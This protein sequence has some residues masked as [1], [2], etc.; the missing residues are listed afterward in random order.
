MSVTFPLDHSG[1]NPA[2]LVSGELHSV[3]EAQ[4][5]DYFFL[6]PQFAPFY[7]DNFQLELI[8]GSTVQ[9]LAEDVH[10]SF[11]IPYVT[12]Q[13]VT[14]KAMYGAVTLHD[15]ENTGILRMRYQTLGGDQV[16]DRLQ[17]LTH[18]AD[19]AYNP[20]T[21]IWD[22]ITNVPNALPPTPHYQDY[23][24]FK[25]QEDVV[26]SLQAIVG[27]IG[28]NSSLTAQNIQS[29][30]ES[31]NSG[32]S[33]AYL[34]RSGGLMEG[35][36]GLS[37]QPTLPEHAVTKQY[38]DEQTINAGALTQIL[39]QYAS[40]PVLQTN[41]NEKVSKTGDVMTGPL[42]LHADPVV[43]QDAARK[44]YVDTLVT[45]LQNTLVQLQ[46]AVTDL[47]ASAANK[48]Q[49]DAQINELSSR[50]MLLGLQRS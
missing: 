9:L 23:E 6:V 14:G 47:Q 28:T 2:C 26:A 16:C 17:V 38:V 21:T 41:L 40:L 15:L 10:Y 29:F 19:K 32:G 30:L 31:F 27:A 25:G 39:Q 37:L 22:I 24:D 35:P 33:Q 42:K 11:A 5:R 48:A 12:G 46:Q 13:R 45:Q 36:L 20:R 7:I 43:S 18:L 49:V 44:G 50:L 4:F 34:R 1:I 8:S 3:N